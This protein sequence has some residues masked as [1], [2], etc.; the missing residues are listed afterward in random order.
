MRA[1]TLF[2][3][4]PISCAGMARSPRLR[5]WA[6]SAGKTPGGGAYSGMM[7][8]RPFGVRQTNSR[9]TATEIR[10]AT[11]RPSRI[12]GRTANGKAARGSGG[13]ANVPA[14]KPTAI[15]TFCWGPR[16]V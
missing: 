10:M 1:A 12:Q 5:N 7:M 6:A 11:A 9:A 4:N 3:A 2:T 8:P 13:V 16:F 15:V 14:V